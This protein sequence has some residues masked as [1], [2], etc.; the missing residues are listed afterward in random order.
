MHDDGRTVFSGDQAYG[1]MHG[2]LADGFHEQWLANIAMLQRDLPGDARLYPGH[3][4]PAGPELLAWQ[5]EYIRTFVD[6]VRAPTGPTRRARAAVV[7]ETTRF[8]PT[9][10]LRFLME[11]SVEPRLPRTSRT[12]TRTSCTSSTRCCGAPTRCDARGR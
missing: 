8:L 10:E 3:G 6:A 7:R 5:A 11:L 2:Y 12:T 1:H 9:D 4:E